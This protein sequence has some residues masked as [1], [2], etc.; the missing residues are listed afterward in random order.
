MKRDF[1]ENWGGEVNEIYEEV[2]K[3]AEKNNLKNKLYEWFMIDHNN[4]S[5]LMGDCHWFN[6]EIYVKKWFNENIKDCHLI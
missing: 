4:Y 5:K 1:D 2:I 3:F 6:S